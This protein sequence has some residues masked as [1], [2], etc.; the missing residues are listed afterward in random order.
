M[1]LHQTK[2]AVTL[3][4]L[5]SL[6]DAH[7]SWHLNEEMDMINSDMKLVDFAF[8]PISNFP[9]E[10]FA[11]HL[12]SVKLHRVHRVFWLP[13]KVE[14]ILPEG[15]IGAFQIHFSSPE[16][17]SNYIQCLVSR[18]LGSNPSLD[19]HF[20]ELNFEGGNSSVG[21][22]TEVPLPLM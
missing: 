6:A 14:G 20:K 2:S 17:S 3:E 4:Q 22:K 7:G 15:M 16:H 18:G 8:F 1:L 10:V 19:N 12:D 13:H 11:I 9:D 5:K 21:L